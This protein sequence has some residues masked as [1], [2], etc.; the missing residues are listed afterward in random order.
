[1]SNFVISRVG[2]VK[3]GVA[4][5]AEA[6]C[7]DVGSTRDAEL[8][9]SREKAT[10][11]S[12]KANDAIV[13]VSYH[14]PKAS[15]ALTLEE[16]TTANLVKALGAVEEGG[17]IKVKTDN[18]DPIYYAVYV[19]GFKVDGVAKVLHIPRCE[20]SADATLKIGGNEQMVLPLSVEAYAD[21]NSTDLFEFVAESTDVTAPT[22]TGVVPADAATGVAK[23]AT[24]VVTWTFSEAIR[25]EDVTSQRFFVH[26]DDGSVK[27]GALTIGTNNTVVTFTPST[28]WAATTKYHT[29]AV[30]GVRDV[31]GNALAA[32]NVTDFTTGA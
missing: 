10:A 22:I 8:K 27:A 24:T 4:G 6:A 20:I 14:S 5:A 16:I 28:A 12:A 26:A 29:V 21:P 11:T 3:I 1:M 9:A 32:T 2:T 31:A 30:A 23:A 15:L 17:A 13:E 19:H 25:T 7:V 18:T